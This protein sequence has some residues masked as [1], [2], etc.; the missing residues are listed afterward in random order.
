MSAHI[1]LAR[2]GLGPPTG[3]RN[4]YEFMTNPHPGILKGYYPLSGF[5]KGSALWRGAGAEPLPAFSAGD[6]YVDYLL[7]CAGHA[8]A[9]EAAY[10]DDGVFDAL[11]DDAVAA[12]ELG[13]V[14]V[15]V[16]ADEACVDG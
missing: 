2:R 12:V 11:G 6:H 13:A 5:P 7:V 1:F 10:V 15:H 3:R 4:T 16:H 9:G 14:H 8:F